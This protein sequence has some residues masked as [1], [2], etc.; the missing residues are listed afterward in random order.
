MLLQIQ[1][2]LGNASLTKTETQDT[3]SIQPIETRTEFKLG[4]QKQAFVRRRNLKPL[5]TPVNGRPSA[6]TLK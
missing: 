4:I 6:L 5:L 1:H 2:N 3:C